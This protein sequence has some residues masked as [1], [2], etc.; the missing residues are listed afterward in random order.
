MA[1]I[2]HGILLAAALLTLQMNPVGATRAEDLPSAAVAQK[3]AQESQTT[4]RP[5]SLGDKLHEFISRWTGRTAEK[6]APAKA[7]SAKASANH[8]AARASSMKPIEP[9]RPTVKEAAWCEDRWPAELCTP[10]S[11]NHTTWAKTA[12]RKTCNSC[13]TMACVY[14]TS[15]CSSS[16]RNHSKTKW[17]PPSWDPEPLPPNWWEPLKSAAPAPDCSCPAGVVRISGSDGQTNNILIQLAH[18]LAFAVAHTPPLMVDLRNMGHIGEFFDLRGATRGWACVALDQTDLMHNCTLP[19]QR[20]FAA[21]DVFHAQ[22]NPVAG[23][24]FR[25]NVLQQILLRPSER[26][27][28]A[29]NAFEQQ[30]GLANGFTAVHLRSLEHECELRVKAQFDLSDDVQVPKY[31]QFLLHEKMDAIDVCSMSNRYLDAIVSHAMVK[32][33]PIVVAHDRQQPSRLADISRTYRGVSYQGVNGV[34]VDM[35]L[36]MRASYMIGNP[37]SSMSG[38]AA[39]VRSLLGLKTNLGD[40]MQ[41]FPLFMRHQM[42]GWTAAES[43][44]Q[45]FTLHRRR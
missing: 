19:I 8:K 37:A 23:Q 3:K 20:E 11:C 42:G 6:P 5:L 9:K 45:R 7:A 41:W 40:P 27:R 1:H 32:H 17:S 38:N 15:S 22:E 36:L 26:L 4:P 12:C 31:I 35:L 44:L 29:V 34:F 10:K 2:M 30:H 14:S 24:S 33:L 39:S 21:Q 18:A 16:R 13:P 28:K 25:A 43:V